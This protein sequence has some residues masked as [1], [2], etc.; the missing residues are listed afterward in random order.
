MSSRIQK[1]VEDQRRHFDS[2]ATRA[3]ST[4]RERLQKLSRALKTFESEILEALHIDLRKPPL[5]TFTSEIA[6]VEKEISV[7]LKSLGKW[8]KPRRVSTPL[9]LIPAKSRIHREPL[10]VVLVIAPWNY[11]LQLALSPLIGAIAAGNCVVIKPSEL[12]PATSRLLA[13]L[14]EATFSAE[15]VSV[16][17]GGV[18]ET[19]ELLQLKFDH[20]F[21]TGSTKVG[22]IVYEAAA[23]TLTPVTLELGG[24]SPVIVHGDADLDLAA[25]RVAWGK[26]MNAGQT[27]VAPDYLYVQDSIA[28]RFLEKL[29]NVIEAHFGN[30]P[31]RSDSFARIVSSG[32]WERLTKLIDPK[33]VY[34]GGKIDREIKYVAP[35]IL[36]DVQWTDPVMQDEIFG[37]LLPVLRYHEIDEALG[38]IRSREKPLAAYLFTNSSF[39]K[40]KFL[41]E[42]SFGGGCVNDTIL[43][44]SSSALPFGGVGASG[45]GAYHGETSFLVFSHQKSVLEKS[46][47]LDLSFRYP[48]YDGWKLKALRFL[49]KLSRVFG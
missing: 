47:W 6:I 17:E 35:T 11:P 9:H 40:R 5:E 14:I 22:R 3:Y 43:H 12:A 4:R 44:L 18:P 20:V 23:K 34:V 36:K 28:D 7:A 10:G 27:C 2:G 32:H 30:D 49:L 46:K 1:L 13:R 41:R 19:T 26:F 37:P 21:F 48:P 38:R 31:A 24:K 29:K 16:V 45:V 8:M 33:K 25:R 15:S 42:L 39:V